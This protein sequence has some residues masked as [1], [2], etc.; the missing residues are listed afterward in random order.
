MGGEKL[1]KLLEQLRNAAPFLV[2]VSGGIDSR[3]LL[4]TALRAGIR[5]EAVHFSGPH[6]SPAERTRSQAWLER[7]GATVHHLRF[8]PLE[9][10]EAG[11]EPR[12]RCYWC[13]RG[14]YAQARELAR[15]RGLARV[16]D[17][18]QTDDLLGHRPGLRALEEH[19]ILM[20]LAGSGLAK[21]EIRLLARGSGLERP[22]QPSRPCLLTR[23]PY[24][25]RPSLQ[26][27][28]A[29][30]RAED[31]LG[32]LGLDRFRLRCL[33]DQGYALHVEAGERVRFLGIRKEAAG[34]LAE[35]GFVDVATVF[36]DRLSGYFDREARR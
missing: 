28:E 17:G 18:T 19:G 36:L 11:E 33:G 14:M 13:K 22:E 35:L 29:L 8:S 9:A 23:F 7:S 24:T 27:L 6:Q 5:C 30:G 12:L 20:P 2:A 16:L 4:H 31:A 34:R 10:R 3:F 21:E 25:H 15:V 32:A 1:A 26:E